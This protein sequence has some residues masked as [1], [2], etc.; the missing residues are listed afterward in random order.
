MTDP[1]QS[2]R[3]KCG[4]RL[5]DHTSIK[6]RC[7]EPSKRCGC[8]LFRDERTTRMFVNDSLTKIAEASQAV[9]QARAGTRGDTQTLFCDAAA[10]SLR[11]AELFLNNVLV[12]LNVEDRKANG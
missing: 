8:Q 3:C 2:P 12:S 1:S 9:A 11:D 6:G 7:I 4:H 10:G 5:Y